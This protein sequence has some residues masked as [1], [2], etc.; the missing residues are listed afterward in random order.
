MV[1]F[2]MIYSHMLIGRLGQIYSTGLHSANLSSLLLNCL[3]LIQWSSFY[4]NG[5]PPPFYFFL[6]LNKLPHVTDVTVNTCSLTFW[7]WLIS[8]S[9]YSL[10][11]HPFT[12]KCY[13]DILLCGW[14]IIHCV[15]IPYF[16]SI[17]L[18]KGTLVIVNCASISIDVVASL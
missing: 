10:Q 17:R 8:L 15:Y 7:F 4:F 16:V 6:V 2:I 12:F 13:D 3:S 1:R 9:L 14:V 5:T 11:F 18:V